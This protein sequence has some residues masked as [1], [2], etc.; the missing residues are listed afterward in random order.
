MEGLRR[1]GIEH[2]GAA[3]VDVP[4][5]QAGW[6]SL[7]D[8]ESRALSPDD[9]PW[10]HR[11]ASVLADS[12]LLLLD[13]RGPDLDAASSFLG[14]LG[15]RC[16][17][18]VHDP[19]EALAAVRREAPCLIVLVMRAP[20][21]AGMTV[22]SALR[23]DPVLRHVPTVVLDATGHPQA[24][25]R[26]LASGAADCLEC[27]VAASELALR[28]R[29]LLAAHAYREYLG[30]HDVLTGLSTRAAYRQAAANVLAESSA[31]ALLLVGADGLAD[32]NDAL[33]QG[34]GDQLL[35]RIAKRLGSCVQTEAGGELSSER[36][37]PMLF[38][39][40]G[41]E[42]A[43]L[44]PH[45]EGGHS[46]AAF[47]NKVL[48]DGT[49]TLHPHG[50]PELFVTCSIGVSVFPRDG[51]D[52]ETLLRHASVALR[53][54]KEAGAHRYE[55]YAPDFGELAQRRLDLS[56]EL[57]HAVRRDQIE[58]LYAPVVD[59]ASGRLAEAQ[60]IVAW[61]HAS[62]RV[63]AGDELMDLA[64]RSEMDVTLTEWMVEQ[65]RKHI[66]NWRAAGLQPVP[67]GLKASLAHMQVRDLVHLVQAAT[68]SGIEPQLLHLQLQQLGNLAAPSPKDA[69]A[70]VA[71]RKKGV[72]LA[73]DRFGACG[74]V[75]DL[76]RLPYDELKV[77]GSLFDDVERDGFQ[78]AMLLGINDL[79]KRLRLSSVACGID[80]PRKLDFVRK[81]GWDRA[82][83]T[84]FGE[85]LEGLAFAA[86]WLTRSGK[87]QRVSIPGELA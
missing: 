12:P 77:D 39:M 25:Q 49:A 9:M 83:G 42:F 13:N 7:S 6:S 36:H 82:Q 1:G 3:P 2:E 23:E 26:S 35:Q 51:D 19:V 66:R 8:A 28:V 41:D 44:V 64:G 37:D 76:R 18:H 45:M 22:L 32:V 4:L 53:Q 34:V 52:P 30:Q 55:F 72:H 5:L 65:A 86:R 73:L 61:R 24:M 81:H 59:L 43:I 70:L 50:R 78:Q 46:T 11:S 33:G 71:L 79:A 27:P 16:L 75:G 85:P 20:V 54:A 48:E 80:T 58:L 40:D 57:R 17:A 84:L 31:G 38:R 15:Y 56:A 68:S 62:G 14:A 60:T 63:I 21:L 67:L 69:S 10:A 29:N 87:P 47:I 74:T